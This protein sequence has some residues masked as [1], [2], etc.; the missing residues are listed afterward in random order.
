MTLTISRKQA[1]Q[2][3]NLLEHLAVQMIVDDTYIRGQMIVTQ[4]TL[5]YLD[6]CRNEDCD[7]MKTCITANTEGRGIS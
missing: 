4:G 6:S 7:L 5:P 2:R 3:A 1:S